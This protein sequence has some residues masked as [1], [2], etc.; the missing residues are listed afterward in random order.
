MVDYI[1]TAFF[2]EDRAD[3]GSSGS[4]PCD[5]NRRIDAWLS[6]WIQA[7]NQHLICDRAMNTLDPVTATLYFR[8]RELYWTVTR[9]LGLGHLH[10]G[11]RV[12]TC[13]S[14]PHLPANSSP[15]HGC[16]RSA[17]GRLFIDVTPTH[18]FGGQTGIQ[19][20]VREVARRAPRSG[21]AMPVIIESGKLLSWYDSPDWSSPLSFAP[22]DRLLLLDACWGLTG[23]YESIIHSL[24]AA[25][26][27]LVTVVHDLIPLTHPL[28]V[29][30]RMHAE[31]QEWF[32]AIVMESD[33]VVCVSRSAASDFIEY[34]EKRA[35]FG[36]PDLPVGWWRLG[37]DFEDEDRRPVSAMA[38]AIFTDTTPCFL[39]VGTLEP[40]KAYPIAL[41]AFEQLWRMG[42]DV[43]YLIVGRPGWQSDALAHDIT[44]HPE[45][46]RRLF[47]LD[48]ASDTDLRFCY[49]HAHAL[50]FPSV[51]EGF[52]LPLVEANRHGLPVIASDLP[53]FRE[54]GGGHVDFVP[55][56]DPRALAE[57]IMELCS[58]T[59]ERKIVVAPS[60]DQSVDS[61]IRLIHEGAY[62]AGARIAARQAAIQGG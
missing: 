5:G 47:W 22:G 61:L 60:W 53:V 55:L 57:K 13:R 27:S 62:Q 44:R 58:R 18:R 10:D 40:R 37:A 28:A 4:S 1:R 12:R 49:R 15:A 16:S 14:R 20:V 6:A 26:G 33:G 38:Q 19:R 46:G 2:D 24:R 51:I 56:L 11:S 50:V 48:R 43:R 45:F 42:V 17:A 59:A 41:N 7:E 30:P 8:A 31:F 36:R 39:S 34:V 25:G 21:F 52:G 3:R 29:S 35:P 9:A 54:I 23:E 32:D